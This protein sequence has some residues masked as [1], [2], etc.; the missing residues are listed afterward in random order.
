MVLHVLNDNNIPVDYMVGAQLKG[1]S[2]MVH[3]TD[4]NDLYYL[5]VM[6]IY[7]HQ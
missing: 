4:E 1:F 6:S 7:L 3:L 2:T 5:K